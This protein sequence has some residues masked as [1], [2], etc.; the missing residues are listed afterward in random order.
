MDGYLPEGYSA[1]SGASNVDVNSSTYICI[2]DEEFKRFFFKNLKRLSLFPVPP[3]HIHVLLCL[4]SCTSIYIK[5]FPYFLTIELLKHKTAILK[6]CNGKGLGISKFKS[7]I[8][9]TKKIYTPNS[10]F[11]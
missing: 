6:I 7:I 2:L 11:S 5:C 8:N 3:A 1:V 9:W 10:Y 4:C